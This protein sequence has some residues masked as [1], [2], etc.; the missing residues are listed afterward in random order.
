MYDIQSYHQAASVAD[1]V[2]ALVRDPEAMPI[3]GGTDV[4][5]QTREGRH[6]GCHLVSIHGLPELREIRREADGTLVIGSGCTFSQIHASPVLR[7][8]V[9]ML[10]DAVDQVGSPQ[11]RNMGTI[12][13]NVCNGVTSADSAPSLLA[14]EAQLELTGPEGVRRVPILEWYTGPGRT[15][16]RRE[17]ILTALRIAPE[18]YEGWY[19]RYLKY[20]KREAMEI[21]TLGCAVRVKLS[22]DRQ[23]VEALRI[24]Y[25]VA[26]PTP[27]RCPESEALAVGRPLDEALVKELG[28]HVLTALQPRDSWRASKAFRFQIAR[29]LCRRAFRQ[30]VIDAGGAIH[31]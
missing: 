29:E 15:V 11:I 4:L 6:A 31:A 28:Q 17:E 24:A 25:G 18:Q 10:C 7:P 30:A 5:I 16:R 23:R 9:P 12:G 21:S 27:V 14:L 3:A 20:G 26:A 2:A 8:R 19:G 22:P 1:A 13:G